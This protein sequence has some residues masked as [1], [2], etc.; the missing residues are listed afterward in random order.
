MG[1]SGISAPPTHE[2]TAGCDALWSHCVVHKVE[3]N[4]RV[5]LRQERQQGLRF[6]IVELGKLLNR[7]IVGLTLTG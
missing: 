5:G 3:H 2:T 6:S 7:C 1:P 4:G